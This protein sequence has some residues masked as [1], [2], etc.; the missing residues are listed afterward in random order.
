LEQKNASHEQTYLMD[1]VN[2]RQKRPPAITCGDNGGISRQTGKPCGNAPLIAI[3][4]FRPYMEDRGEHDNP[5]A[6]NAIVG[7]SRKSTFGSF[8]DG[9]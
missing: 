8:Y 4:A 1:K 7:R 3:A 2:E 5:I 9:W 6:P